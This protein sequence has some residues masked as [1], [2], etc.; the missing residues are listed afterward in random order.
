MLG[1]DDYPDIAAKLQSILAGEQHH[2]HTPQDRRKLLPITPGERGSAA[3]A[4]VVP[5]TR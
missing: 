1:F 5:G 4:V 2:P 3:D